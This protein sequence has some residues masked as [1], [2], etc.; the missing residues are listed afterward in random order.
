MNIPL[1]PPPRRWLTRRELWRLYRA[2]LRDHRHV[3][4]QL[5]VVLGISIGVAL[6]FGSQVA[7]TSLSSAVQQLNSQIIGATRYQ[8][9]ARGPKGFSSSVAE[10]VSRIPGVTKA[11]PVLEQPATLVGPSGSQAVDLLGVSPQFVEAGGPL[12]RRFSASELTHQ[13]ALALPAPLA[14]SVG[15]EDFQKVRLQIDGRTRNTVVAAVL[16]AKEI[17]E[18]TQSPIVVA[19]IAY[20]QQ[21]ANMVGKVTRIFVQT[22]PGNQQPVH[23]ALARLAR[24]QQLNLEPANSE[25]IQFAVAAS[26]QSQGEGLFAAIS[27]IVGFVFAFNAI[28]L[29]I[30]SRRTFVGKLRRVSY[31]REMTI[32]VLAI[33]ALALGVVASGVGIVLGELLSIE[34]FRTKPGYLSY[35]FPV[36]APRIVTVRTVALSVSAGIAAAA[37]GVFL[38]TRDLL[39]PST[40]NS[41][42]AL[43]SLRLGSGKVSSAAI[44]AVIRFRVTIGVAGLAITTVI[45]LLRPQSAVL[46]NVTL[47]VALVCLLPSFL[48]LVLRAFDRL[49]SLTRTASP[50]LALI[51]LRDPALKV[52]SLVVALTGAVA[53]FGAVAVQGAQ[54]NLQAGLDKTATEMNDVTSLWVSPS[55]QANALGTTPFES[56]T[57]AAKLKQLDTVRSVSVYRGGFLTMGRRRIWIIAPPDTSTALAPPG[58]LVSGDP[59]LAAARV[60]AG[61]WAVVS[62]AI[63]KE[64]NLRVGAS[65]VLP[66]PLSVKLRVAALSTNMGWPPG[67]IIINA[68]EY[69]HGWGANEASALNVTIAPWASPA[70]VRQEALVAVHGVSSGFDVQTASERAQNWK[71]ISKQGLSRLSQI[72]A[73][74]LVAAILAISGIMCSIIWQRQPNLASLKRCAYSRGCLWRALF[75]ECAVLLFTGCFMGAIFGLYGQLVI[76][77]ALQ[78]VTGFPMIIG[79]GTSLAVSSCIIV[80]ASALAILTAFGYLAVRVRTAVRPLG[81]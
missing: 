46:G 28:L 42:G 25:A 5:L 62:E 10:D 30:V 50:K 19:P 12:L 81:A 38:P 61:G 70:R 72:A 18:L 57:I 34:F 40:I 27:A 37:A 21:L 75:W 14:T 26:P 80:C 6:L 31:S 39:R 44:S 59:Q 11:L 74:V 8:I 9:I 33:E 23:A 15:V 22:R 69:R 49:Q 51:E 20:A 48:G 13:R 78:T 79:V 71:T 54:R 58:Q 66:S 3:I 76:S 56:A 29:S 1:A 32:Q 7:S 68:S 64:R 73:L 2:R 60:R 47:L 24:S 65:F 41:R 52:R 36:G 43:A 63:A 45:I 67:A 4:Q 53:V 77:H 35:A 17:G 16:T 55:G